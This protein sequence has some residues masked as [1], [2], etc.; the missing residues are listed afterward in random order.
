MLSHHRGI[1]HHAHRDKEHGAEQVLHWI[2]QPLDAFSL[3]GTGKDGTHYKGAQCRRE[4]RFDGKQ[5]HRKAQSHG[6][7]EHLLVADITLEAFKQRGNNKNSHRE[8]HDQEEG[9]LED[10]AHHFPALDTIVQC[11]R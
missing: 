1:D 8:P 4:S 2:D 7:D 6:D 11:N 10:A 9:Q 5:H 3:D